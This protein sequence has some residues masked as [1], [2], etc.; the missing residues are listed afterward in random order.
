MARSSDTELV[1]PVPDNLRRRLLA[2]LSEDSASRMTYDEFL[3]WADEDSLA[4]WVDGAIVMASPA[5]ATS[6]DQDVSHAYTVALCG[7]A[8]AWQ[9]L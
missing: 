8:S 2:A 5:S 3:E 4:E 6:G 1:W 9:D 7:C